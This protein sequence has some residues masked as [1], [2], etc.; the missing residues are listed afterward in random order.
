MIFCQY[1]TLYENQLKG[2]IFLNCDRI[3]K[4]NFEFSRQKMA[5]LRAKRA[6]SKYLNF[7]AKNTNMKV[8]MR[9]F[10]WFSNFIVTWCLIEHEWQ[11]HRIFMYLRHDVRFMDE[12]YTE[13]K[14]GIF[15]YWI[16]KILPYENISHSI[17]Y[18]WYIDAIQTCKVHIM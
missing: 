16:W 17:W 18:P 14:Y 3:I 8:R 9:H 4:Q 7:R 6:P 11:L 13:F 15:L 10:P 12:W 2:R 5:T 1:I